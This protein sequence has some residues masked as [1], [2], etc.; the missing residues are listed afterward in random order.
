VQESE[1]GAG[2][3]GEYQ[4][5]ER[6]QL[7]LGVVRQKTNRANLLAWSRATTSTEIQR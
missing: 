4:I 7:D 1:R 3:V 6:Q 2:V 5:Q